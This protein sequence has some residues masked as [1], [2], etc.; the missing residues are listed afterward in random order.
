MSQ[1]EMRSATSA[2]A[3]PVSTAGPWMLPYNSRKLEKDPPSDA[4]ASSHI[5]S[6]ALCTLQQRLLLAAAQTAQGRGRDSRE[7]LSD[8]RGRSC[9]KRKTISCRTVLRRAANELNPRRAGRVGVPVP[10]IKKN[11]ARGDESTEAR[12]SPYQR[13]REK[14]N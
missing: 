12:V 3:A 2:N 5:Q 8:T 14:R 7:D 11:S 13:K 10:K 1:S 9:W 6:K 4:I